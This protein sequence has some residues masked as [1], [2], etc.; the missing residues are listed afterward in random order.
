MI[1]AIIPF[2]KQVFHVRN[3]TYVCVRAP[4]GKCR[5]AVMFFQR[6]KWRMLLNIQLQG[7]HPS[8]IPA[9][10]AKKAKQEHESDRR[11]RSARVRFRGCAESLKQV[12]TPCSSV[13]RIILRVL[14]NHILLLV[15][16]VM[17]R[18]S[19]FHHVEHVAKKCRW[20]WKATH[21]TPNDTDK[22]MSMQF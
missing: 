12:H 16:S 22:Q 21:H 19:I 3:R 17:R 18:A 20:W 7:W 6:Q 5:F 2:C 4:K 9:S 8:K 11:S 14:M 10:Q 15:S 1:V 13:G